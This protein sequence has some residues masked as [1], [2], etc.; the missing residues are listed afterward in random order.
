MRWIT[1]WVFCFWAANVW[2][3]G[4]DF[5]DTRWGM[6][7]Q[8]VK[9]TESG[10]VWKEEDGFLGYLETVA[11]FSTV[12]I[13]VFVEDRLVR[14][15]YDFTQRHSNK[16]EYLA[17]YETIKQILLKKY[18]KP[19]SNERIWS[20]SLFQNDPQQYGLA[21][22]RGDMFQMAEWSLPKTEIVLVLSG[23]NFEI[24]LV[25]E[26]VSRALKHLEEEQQEQQ[27]ADQF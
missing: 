1:I 9:A 22:A 13:Y 19:D 25:A 12:L 3:A 21:V 6:S 5:R 2:A 26:Y 15:R 20:N 23:D 27:H 4:F 18:G 8:E 14:A 24:H 17:D 7:M 10:K 11:G 16:N